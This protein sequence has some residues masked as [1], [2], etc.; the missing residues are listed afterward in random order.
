M[1]KITAILAALSL[2]LIFNTGC[3]PEL[4]TSIKLPEEDPKLALSAFLVAGDTMHILFLGGSQ[5]NNIS[6]FQNPFVHNGV[7]KLIHGNDTMPLINLGDGLYGFTSSMMQILP[8]ETY[9]LIAWAPGYEYQISARC[10]IP[11][12]FDPQFVFKSVEMGKPT[13]WGIRYDVE[14]SFKDIAGSKDFYR[15]F[16]YVNVERKDAFGGHDTMTWM[17][18]SPESQ[19]QLIKDAGKDGNTIPLKLSFEMPNYEGESYK[20]LSFD[21]TILRTDEAYYKFNYPFVVQGY[22]EDNPF[23]EPTVI[24]SNV[25]NGY[26]VLAGA[27]RWSQRITL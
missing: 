1:N 20:I 10:T 11:G 19:P 17:L 4:V 12:V 14:V 24:Y 25:T 18:Y 13:D 23:G 2:A 7:V 26:G 16:A 5:P 27:V 3:E 6:G 8:G 15:V 9:A 21:F 22:Y